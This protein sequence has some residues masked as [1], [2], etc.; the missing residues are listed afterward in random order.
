MALRANFSLLHSELNDFL[1]AHLGE[2]ENGSPRTVLSA[3]TR[4]GADP[5]EEGA[6]LSELPR[7]AAVRALVTM[8]AMFPQE[9]R[10]F[11]EVT[12]L[13]EKL[14]GLLPRRLDAPTGIVGT[15]KRRRTSRSWQDWLA[16]IVDDLR[17]PGRMSLLPWLALAVCA[18]IFV[19]WLSG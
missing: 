19:S 2:E 9:K 7:D 14:A 10:G 11:S 12:A 1:F 8:I 5:W 13:A 18:A 4:L 15:R 16:R 6:R 17:S 3:L